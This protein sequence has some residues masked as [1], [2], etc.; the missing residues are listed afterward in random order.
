MRTKQPAADPR[1]PSEGV[2]GTRWRETCQ[3]IPKL[4]V[5]LQLNRLSEARRSEVE[6][7][8]RVCSGCRLKHLALTLAAGVVEFRSAQLV[9]EEG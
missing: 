5:S 4:L 2:A 7:H 6:E 8:L 3:G 1:P 9:G